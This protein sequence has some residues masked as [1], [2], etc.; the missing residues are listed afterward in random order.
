M[1]LYKKNQMDKKI[2]LSLSTVINGGAGNYA[3]QNHRLLLNLG[4][5]SYLIV[6]DKP[7]NNSTNVIQYPDSKGKYIFSRM[8]RM[9]WRFILDKF[10]YNEKYFFTINM[11]KLIVIRLRRF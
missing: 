6:K 9:I 1:V 7:V 4:Y 11:S 8:K 5:D 3:L 2:I 10:D